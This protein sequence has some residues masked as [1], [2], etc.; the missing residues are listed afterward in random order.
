MYRNSVMH[1]A[2]H[3]FLLKTPSFWPAVFLSNYCMICIGSPWSCTSCSRK[4][5][6]SAVQQIIKTVTDDI[7][8]GQ[9]FLVSIFYYAR[10]FSLSE[11]K[12]STLC[13]AV[14]RNPCPELQLE[15]Q[16]HRFSSMILLRRTMKLS[17]S[18]KGYKVRHM[19]DKTLVKYRIVIF[20]N[21]NVF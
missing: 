9:H 5:G 11:F 7:K 17:N 12:V 18:V 14:V 2:L 1:E 4:L 3:I 19:F 20:N 8:V 16:P 21:I 6:I 10:R 13:R 15:K